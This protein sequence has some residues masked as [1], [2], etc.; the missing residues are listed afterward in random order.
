M[1]ESITTV[2]MLAVPEHAPDHPEKVEPAFGLAVNV[3]EVPAL[4]EEPE[5]L[6]LTVPVP[7]PLTEVVR[8]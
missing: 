6:A 4:N 7:V 2:H 1:L 3:T 8:V 5:G